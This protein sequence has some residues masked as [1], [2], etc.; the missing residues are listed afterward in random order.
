MSINV[1]AVIHCLPNEDKSTFQCAEIAA[2][3][4]C[5]GVFLIDHQPPEH[6]ISLID[7]AKATKAR[8]PL[9]QVGV[10]HLDLPFTTSFL[11]I[12]DAGLDATWA[13]NCG[14][15]NG[16]A[17]GTTAELSEFL[18]QEPHQFFGSVAFKGQIPDTDP[19]ASACRALELGLIP[20]TSGPATGKAVD[21]SKLQ[22]IR[23]AI[24]HA[25]RLALASGVSV[26]NIASY[27]GLVTD[28][29][30]NSSI[31]VPGNDALLCPQR[32]ATLVQAAQG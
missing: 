12:T 9:L 7:L 24:G 14:I 17:S 19:A 6:R 20:T 1:W 11:A 8:Y 4:G 15:R 3:A 13:D 25:A 31:C 18:S 21:R 23:E 22:R 2:Q 32:T 26:D 5:H 10:N 28:V 30:V 29:L 16:R 27:H